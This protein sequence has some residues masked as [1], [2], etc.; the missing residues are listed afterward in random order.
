MRAILR[1]AV[2]CTMRGWARDQ[3][4]ED[5]TV[6]TALQTWKN[7][8]IRWPIRRFKQNLAEII[9]RESAILRV[10]KMDQDGHDFAL[11]QV[12]RATTVS[13]S[14]QL[15]LL[16]TRSKS[17]PEVIDSTEQFE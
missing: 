11:A 17:L 2:T 13:T 15:L 4:A 3:A 5:E 1:A 16:P 14:G 10:M 9:R 6:Q 8:C 12:G 7:A